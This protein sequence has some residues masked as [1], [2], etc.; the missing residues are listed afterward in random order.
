MIPGKVSNR[1]ATLGKP[2][3]SGDDPGGTVFI[4]VVPS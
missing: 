3:A 2:R 4:D 1:K